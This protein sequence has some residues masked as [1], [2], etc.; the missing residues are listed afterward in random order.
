MLL[1]NYY[2]YDPIFYFTIYLDRYIH[3][4]CTL[5]SIGSVSV[6]QVLPQSY[7]E[8]G[9]TCTVCNLYFVLPQPNGSVS[10]PIADFSVFKTI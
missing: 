4:L 6:I 8:G 10:F 7:R 5:K 1:I 9:L 3:V 2:Y